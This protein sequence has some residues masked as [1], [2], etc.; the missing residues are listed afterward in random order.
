MICL[1][2][3]P[4]V[5]PIIAITEDQVVGV[6]L[7]ISSFATTSS[8]VKTPPLNSYRKQQK[9]LR[10][11][12]RVLARRKKGSAN[13]TKARLKVAK[14]HQKTRNQR[15]DFTHKLSNEIANHY[16]FVAVEDLNVRGMV[17]NRH[18][19][20][21]ISDQG[22]AMFL[23]QLRYKTQWAGGR[24][25]QIDRFAPSTKTCS[26]CG[27]TQDMPPGVRVYDCG[28]CGS[29]IDRDVNAAI[30]IRR[31]GL[32]QLNRAGT[33]RIHACGD[34]S[35]GDQVRNWSRYVSEKQE[36]FLAIGKEAA[37]SLESQ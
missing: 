22:W 16:L 21:S 18:L 10:R 7:G 2:E 23:D 15:R 20:K 11:A 33:V 6:D 32:E 24:V 9:K 36:N 13:R 29:V 1:C 25:I 14:I 35:I 28:G 30:N 34:T 17:K 8:G 4:D 31:W 12:Q 37:I 5:A 19:A 26:S 27:H 3:V